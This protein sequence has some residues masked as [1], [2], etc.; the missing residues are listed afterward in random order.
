M[1]WPDWGFRATI[2]RCSEQGNARHRF[3]VQGVDDRIVLRAVS[4]IRSSL[5]AFRRQGRRYA[6]RLRRFVVHNLL[7][8]DD[9]PHKLALGFAIGMFITLTPTMGFQMAL[10]V[11]FAWM[12]RANKTVGVPLVW[13]TNPATMVPIYY[14]MYL[15]GQRMLGTEHV[16]LEWWSELAKAPPTEGWWDTAMFYWHKTLEIAAPLWAGCIVVGLTAGVIS[17]VAV[18]YAV[19]AYRMRR[20]GQVL[21]PDRSPPSD[22]VTRS[23]KQAA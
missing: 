11:F 13:I 16:G 2:P 12:L 1:A 15:V 19:V 18:Y 22:S 17:Y 10:V 9:P 6:T 8:A 5:H 4:L 21:P 3:R 23:T 20:W 14:P 7:H